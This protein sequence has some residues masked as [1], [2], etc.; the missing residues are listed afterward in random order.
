M[1]NDFA[2]LDIKIKFFPFSITIETQENDMFYFTFLNNLLPT[3]HS[4]QRLFWQ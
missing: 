3:T 2:F 4:K 1:E